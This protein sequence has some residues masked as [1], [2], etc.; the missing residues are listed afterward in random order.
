MEQG[1]FARVKIAVRRRDAIDAVERDGVEQLSVGYYAI[2]DDVA[3]THPEFGPY[4][5]RQIGRKSNHVA[6]V[7]RGRAGSSVAILRADSADAISTGAVSAH[8]ASTVRVARD[9]ASAPASATT[10]A[11]PATTHEDAPMHK[12]LILLLSALGVERLDNEDT[13]LHEGLTAARKIA[14]DAAAFKARADKEDADAEELTKAKEEAK[15]AKA[16][17]EKAAGQVAALQ[18][19]VDALEAAE[20]TRKDAADLADLRALAA[21]VKLDGADKLDAP[22]LRLALVQTRVP[23]AAADWSAERMDGVLSVVRADAAD[24]KRAGW[25]GKMPVTVG[26]RADASGG[27]HRLDADE[28]AIPTLDHALNVSTTH[29]GAK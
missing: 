23:S 12:S 3:G 11:P 13:A 1:G 22:A 18:A 25:D 9:A 5:A 21:V 4:D 14:A 16:D 17:A 27:G 8:A 19:K 15:M 24:P 28:F 10:P 2:M 26:A 29:G 20:K 7:P 6:I